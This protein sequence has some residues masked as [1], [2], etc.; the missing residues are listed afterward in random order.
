MEE[1]DW[2]CYIKQYEV[3]LDECTAEHCYI[4]YEVNLD[5]CTAEKIYIGWANQ[6]VSIQ[7]WT[8]RNIS[9]IIHN[10]VE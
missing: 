8:Y 1:E 5:K 4:Q 3:N 10:Y 2:H 9:R 6:L 7:L